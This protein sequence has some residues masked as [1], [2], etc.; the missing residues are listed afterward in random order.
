MN[1]VRCPAGHLA[2]VGKKKLLISEKYP[3]LFIYFCPACNKKHVQDGRWWYETGPGHEDQMLAEA[4][5]IAS[6]ELKRREFLDAPLEHPWFSEI[7]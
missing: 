4:V 3:G 1:Q 5:D 7:T 6:L 2:L